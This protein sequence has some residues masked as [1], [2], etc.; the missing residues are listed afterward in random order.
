M[1]TAVGISLGSGEHNF[2]FET[3]FLGRR[4]RVWRIGTDASVTKTVRMLK[5]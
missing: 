2:D 5:C 1:K 3:E 4:I